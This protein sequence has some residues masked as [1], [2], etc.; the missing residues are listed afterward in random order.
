MRISLWVLVACLVAACGPGCMYPEEW[1]R[2]WAQFEK[3][4][5]QP[6]ANP[7]PEPK[8]A[9][10]RGTIGRK[11]TIEGLRFNR[12][13]GYGLVVNLVDTGGSGGPEV[14]KKYLAKEM[15]RRQGIGQPAIPANQIIEDRDTAMVDVT[16]EIPTAAERGTRIDLVVRALG[17][18]SES[19]VGGLLVLCELKR[20]AESP[21]GVISGKTVAIGKG[22]VFVTPFGRDEESATS[23]TPTVGMILGGGIVKEPRRV[24]LIL[25]DPSYSSAQQIRRRLNDRYGSLTPVAD[26]ISPSLVNIE[27]P[28]DHRHRKKVFLDLVMHTTLRA[29]R[30][31]LETRIGEL[32]RETVHPDA[33]YEAISLAWEAIGQSAL[34]T[35]RRFYT[36]TSSATRYYAGRT[37]MRLGDEDGIAVVADFARNPASVLR[38]PAIEELGYA[39][40]KVH[41]AGEVLRKLLDDSDVRVRIAAYES[42]RRQNHPSINTVSLNDE[43]VILD[44]VASDGPFLIYAQRSLQPRIAIF[45][46]Q[47]ACRPPVI[48]PEPSNDSKSPFT[49]IRINADV[50][51]E[52]L[53]ILRFNR[54]S[55]VVSPPLSAPVNICALIK[56]LAGRPETDRNGQLRGLGVPYSE[57]IDILYGL[58]RSGAI[59]AILEVERPR[60]TEDLLIRRARER[61][62]SEH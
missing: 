53:T 42:L 37:G 34:P 47:L 22:P 62:E 60:V 8:S 10:L 14:V 9:A 25:T 40:F 36:H 46:S 6:T 35:V 56:Y 5:S 30:R 17:D 21:R 52:K 28:P 13:R 29:D 45:G 12:V 16:G 49:L 44:I 38:M 7:R 1:Q 27:I 32:A 58:C 31:F 15:R 43:M 19:L 55:R 26:A 3:P 11:V 41:P 54:V 23:L 48:Y 2:W 39:A 59:P 33:D 24:R 61:P 51:A 20:Y 57:I 4:G 50:G 18:D